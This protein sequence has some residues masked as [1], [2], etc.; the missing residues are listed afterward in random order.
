MRFSIAL[1]ATSLLALTEAR[2]VGISVPKTIKP[3]E[4]FEAII[5]SENYIQSVYDVAIA[6]GY[7][8]GK[9]FP[10]SL[11]QV[12]DSFYLGPGKTYSCFF[13]CVCD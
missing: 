7:S 11:G 8:P 4:D 6:F 1:A 5:I 13:I 12:A 3:G 9:G 10:G 2:I